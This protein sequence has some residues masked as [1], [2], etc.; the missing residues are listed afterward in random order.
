M[1]VCR[2][3]AER[4]NVG[5]SLIVARLRRLKYLLCKKY[6]L[7]T[8]YKSLEYGLEYDAQTDRQNGYR[9]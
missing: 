4:E 8:F 3:E 7:N 1:G 9:G 5:N 2:C 6:S